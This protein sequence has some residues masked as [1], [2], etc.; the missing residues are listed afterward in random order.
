MT[1][2]KLLTDRQDRILR[3]LAEHSTSQLD[4][5]VVALGMSEKEAKS[6]IAVLP[7]YNFVEVSPARLLKEIRC[8]MKTAI[9]QT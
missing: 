1:A 4:P 3:L 9:T 2:P 7:E 5:I 8:C 6:D